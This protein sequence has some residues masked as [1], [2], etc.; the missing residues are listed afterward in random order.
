ML[1]SLLLACSGGGGGASPVVPPLP[2]PVQVPPGSGGLRITMAGTWEIRGSTLV[3]TNSPNPILP[4]DGTK[5][6]IG[7]TG[8]GSVGILSIGGFTVDRT[9]LEALLGFAFDWYVN[10]ADGKILLYGL[11][12]DRRA[13]GGI[14][15]QVG[16]AGGTIDDNSIAIESYSSTQ[17]AGQ[18][19]VYQRAHYT[20]ARLSV[21]TLQHQEEGLKASELGQPGSLEQLLR[22][23]FNGR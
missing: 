8:S 12:Y 16:L 9:L 18:D 11:G 17:V 13:R 20:L 3:D 10:E 2:A 5:I 21:S 22:Q 6:V 23:V 14:R 4:V 7:S 19:E 1:A 15:E